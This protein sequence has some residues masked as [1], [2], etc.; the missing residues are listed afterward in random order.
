MTYAD[1]SFITWSSVAEGLLKELSK[2]EG[3][4]RK[5]PRYTK[6]LKGMEERDAVKKIRDLMARGRVEHG[7]K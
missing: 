5:F 4:E 2:F 6:W 3:L 7:L 1:L